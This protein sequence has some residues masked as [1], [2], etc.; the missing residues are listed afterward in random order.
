MP[1]HTLFTSPERHLGSLALLVCATFVLV[2]GWSYP[3]GSITQMGPGYFPRIIGVLMLG[4]GAL[5]L[6]SE[7]REEKAQPSQ[8]HWRNIGFT[9][10]SVLA[11]AA[12]IDKAGLVPATFAAV[13]LSK[14]AD[15]AARP[16]D[17][18]IYTLFVCLGAWV[19]FIQILGLPLAA[20][21]RG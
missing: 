20:F 8:M 18:V 12:L 6:L 4:F 5:C 10:V 3:A 19:L 9:A 14:F 21:G 17:A 13:L 1:F 15:N 16:V 2:V 11:F 7:L